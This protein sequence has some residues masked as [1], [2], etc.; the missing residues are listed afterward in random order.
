M[1]FIHYDFSDII[2]L[3]IRNFN[4]K[5]ISST[6]DE[7]QY[8]Y[9]R[10]EK[11]IKKVGGE[12]FNKLDTPIQNKVIEESIQGHIKEAPL[13]S[14][15]KH[16]EKANEA[17]EQFEKLK[18][19]PDKDD[20]RIGTLKK[21]L[22]RVGL[23]NTL[24]AIEREENYHVK[25]DFHRFLVQ[26][27]KHGFKVYIKKKQRELE[28]GL[29]ST[30]FEVRLP[31]ATPLKEGEQEK[32]LAEILQ[33]M[34]QF[35]ISLLPIG[36]DKKFKSFSLELAFIPGEEKVKFFCIV[37]DKYI[38]IFKN[39]LL[40]I[41]PKASVYETY[42][43]YNIFNDDDE[44]VIH[45]AKL[46]EHIFLPLKT[47]QDMEYDP[48]NILLKAFSLFNH[49]DGAA[50]QLV[51][52]PATDKNK[53]INEKLELF[54]NPKKKIEEI[55]EPEE[56]PSFFLR[57]LDFVILGAMENFVKG[58]GYLLG[59]KEEEKKDE[60]DEE[61]Q[62]KSV[63]S[64]LLK[65]KNSS[66][67]F[68]VNIR[69]ITSSQQKHTA[70][71]MAETIISAFKQFDNSVGNRIVFKRIDKELI[72]SYVRKFIYRIFDNKKAI[73]LNSIELSS[74]FH[75]PFN[76]LESTEVLTYSNT[77]SKVSLDM[78]QIAHEHNAQINQ[79]NYEKEGDL[80]IK[81]MNSN[82]LNTNIKNTNNSNS[83]NIVPEDNHLSEDDDK[84]ISIIN[85]NISDKVEHNY[86]LNNNN[87][88]N[89]N[90]QLQENQHDITDSEK[91]VTETE[92]QKPVNLDGS[93]V[94][95]GFNDY[96]G[97]ETP[98]YQKPADRL[99]HTYVVGQTGTG[100]TS[101][102]KNMIVQDIRNGEGVCFIDPHGSDI[103]DILAL[104]PPER[105]DDVIYFDP[106]NI[107]MPMGLNML[108]Y[109]QNHPEQKSFV[110]DEL[111]SI[112]KKLYKDVPESMGP[113]FEQYFRN[114]T[115]LVLEDPESGNTMLEISRVMVDETFREL[116]LLSCQNVLVKQF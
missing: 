82:P 67:L 50:V 17:I 65:K 89:I 85:Q 56:K 59:I 47:Y 104:I 27:L 94:L 37:P 116:K 71:N 79:R 23:F 68:N 29:K 107:E 26:Y 108:E 102:L 14:T 39:A 96:Q 9:D 21:L 91:V 100:K 7:T 6:Q 36:D 52:S 35:Y 115:L 4:K 77:S 5:Q 101:I 63:L 40:S 78:S 62:R 90:A 49:K 109:D 88:N 87:N 45:E 70:E 57:F 69:I 46:G 54:S 95:L 18:L 58:I 22:D 75:F 97:Q 16:L 111:L 53:E 73:L 15:T 12:D 92:Y 55:F 30:V 38:L 103:E 114:A 76:R 105:V 99:R 10:V 11:V 81:Q 110:T 25:D 43:D 31:V 83:T 64:E 51:I 98:I 66:T 8:F 61:A 3:M 113:A 80:F 44:V 60:P 13:I 48:L 106:T 34:D 28:T 33:L 1:W 42:N 86:D 84:Q 112:F 32:K 24:K 20:K 19:D 93:S 41:F 2:I 72:N 74:I